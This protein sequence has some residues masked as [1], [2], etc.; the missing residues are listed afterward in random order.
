MVLKKLQELTANELRI[1]LRRAGI[2]GKYVK[3]EAI[4]RLTTYLIDVSE[5]P[6]SFEFDPDV[7]VEADTDNAD[8]DEYEVVTDTPDTMTVITSSAGVAA[9]SVSGLVNAISSGTL[10][11][12]SSAT[13]TTA[14][15]PFVSTP[16]T[17]STAAPTST[18]T[19]TSSTS[20]FPYP[21]MG[22]YVPPPTPHMQFQNPYIPMQY[23][24]M[25]GGDF[26]GRYQ[27]IPPSSSPAFHGLPPTGPAPPWPGMWTPWGGW[28][29]LGQ[30]LMTPAA[31]PVTATPT[32]SSCMSPGMSSSTVLNPAMAEFTG[33][34]PP[35]ARSSE[36]KST[37][38]TSGQYDSG[39]REVKERQKWPQVMIDHI[40]NP[41]PFDYDEM[42]WA[43]LTAGMTG[44]ILAEMNPAA[45]DIATVN[46]LKH[47]N[48]LANYGMKTPVKSILNFNAVLFR[49]VEN[50]TLSWNNWEKIDQF[51]TRHLSSLTVA[52]I[53]SGAGKSASGSGSGGASMK[54]PSW[55]TLRKSMTEHHM[56]FKFNK[57]RCDQEDDHDT[58]GN[59]KTLLHACGMCAFANRGIVKTHGAQE[60]KPDFWPAP[61]RSQ[62]RAT[63]GGSVQEN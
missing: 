5:D 53:T 57:A 62:H 28:T 10:T 18:L 59:G 32:V 56:C 34:C 49:A 39:R 4:M 17:S 51:H 36:T 25:Q 43:S 9:A 60:C 48:R 1:E 63:G 31:A 37:K 30:P 29:P 16:S 42:D 33:A 24:G 45:I 61:F 20:S 58:N 19:M 23:P 52:A 21:H 47:L 13:A 46:K 12:T 27:A 7:P 15:T 55:E 14:S 3:A 40:L 41:E 35:P 50:Q 54:K 38:I 2:K 6:L 22:G 11:T 44:K 8:G 26:Y